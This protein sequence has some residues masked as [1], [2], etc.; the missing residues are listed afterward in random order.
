M[1]APNNPNIGHH[2]NN[3]MN[4]M[5]GPPLNGQYANGQ[6]QPPSIGGN[7]N[8]SGNRGAMPPPQTASAPPQDGTVEAMLKQAAESGDTGAV[9][10]MLERGAPFVVDMVSY[11]ENIYC[12]S[13]R[14]LC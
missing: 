10:N 4:G 1:S 6:S 3:M 7:V 8:A 12:I 9:I 11:F 5:M 14:K 2:I 13:D